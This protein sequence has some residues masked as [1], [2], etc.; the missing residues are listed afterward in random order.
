MPAVRFS[1]FVKDTISLPCSLP[2]NMSPSPGSFNVYSHHPLLSPFQ[3]T[4][5]YPRPPACLLQSLND[6]IHT[7]VPAPLPCLLSPPAPYASSALSMTPFSSP[8]PCPLPHPLCPRTLPLV[9]VPHGSPPARARFPPSVNDTIPV[10][11]PPPG[12]PPPSYPR[13]FFPA[14]SMTPFYNSLRS[15]VN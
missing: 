1:C 5:S 10:P 2:Y 14:P 8:V 7:P 13:T 12:V 6:T 11:V 4:R 9:P 15:F 3:V